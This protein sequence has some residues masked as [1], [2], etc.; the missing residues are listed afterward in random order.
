VD[1]PLAVTEPPLNPHGGRAAFAELAFE[2]YGAPALHFL[3]P[4]AA[5]FSLYHSQGR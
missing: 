4:G 1:H 2:T 3:D 5:A